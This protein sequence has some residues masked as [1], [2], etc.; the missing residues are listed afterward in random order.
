ME[1]PEDDEFGLDFVCEHKGER[2]RVEAR[3][4]DLVSPFPAG[5]L[6]RRLPGREK[7]L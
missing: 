3:S 7:G 1:W 6:Y 5:H 4:V 2:H